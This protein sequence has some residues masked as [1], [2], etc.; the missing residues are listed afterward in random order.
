MFLEV[1]I[2]EKFIPD[3]TALLA[4]DAYRMLRFSTG[5]LRGISLRRLI[6]A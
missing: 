2:Y 3:G 1:I 4:E 5:V 6:R